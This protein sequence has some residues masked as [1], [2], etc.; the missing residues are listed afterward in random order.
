MP[1]DTK[2]ASTTFKVED[3]LDGT[4]PF[5]HHASVS[6]LWKHKWRNAC[7]QGAYPFIHGNVD[8]FDGIFERLI[9]VSNDDRSIFD[10]CDKYPDAF[11]PV[12]IALSEKAEACEKRGENEAASQLFLRASAVFRIARFPIIHPESPSSM[13]AWNLGK[14]A[15]LRGAK[16]WP[17]PPHEVTI[18]FETGKVEAGNSTADIEG[19]LRLPSQRLTPS[20]GWPV[21]IYICG[22]DAY[23]TDSAFGIDPHLAQG[24]AVICLEIPGTGDCPASA[25]D[26]RSWDRLFDSVLAWIGSTGRTQFSLNRSII[27]ARGIS[28]GSYYALRVA[29]THADQLRGV[30]AQGTW[31]HYALSPSWLTRVDKGEYPFGLSSAFAFRLGYPSLQDALKDDIQKKYSLHLSG[32]LDRPSCPI[33]LV[34]GMEDSVFP[35]EDTWVVAQ[36]GRPKNVRVV[37]GA[38][39]MGRPDG[40]EAVVQWAKDRLQESSS[41]AS[42]NILKLVSVNNAPDRAR[43]LI[44]RV[45]ETFR[46][47]HQIVHA[48]NVERLDAARTVLEAVRP[49]LV[50]TASM[51]TPEESARCMVE[52][53]RVNPAVKT[54]VLPTGLRVEKG[55]D[56]VVE[57]IVE[58]LE[59]TLSAEK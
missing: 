50:F 57:W 56:G 1:D 35:I 42:N 37:Q 58:H 31:C 38:G 7:A 24:F 19:Y 3:V 15:F 13:K 4:T 5:Q 52:A 47:E 46:T 32:I 22:L 18:P 12:G 11:L 51:W 55:N 2:L 16:Y 8:D 23:R 49:D 39:H 30:I 43:E 54:V 17:S 9:Q 36:H 10:E 40:E 20:R 48:A 28:T 21:L 33:L 41:A 25:R 45:I 44:G 53:R 6:A 59:E 29:H 27:F 26:P 34:T 14:I